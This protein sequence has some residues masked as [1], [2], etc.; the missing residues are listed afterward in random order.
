MD[1]DELKF[2]DDESDSSSDEELLENKE[3]GK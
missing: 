2:L 1:I 3:N